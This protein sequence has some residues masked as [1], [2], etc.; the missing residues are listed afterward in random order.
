MV[1]GEVMYRK[2]WCG[3]S[4]GVGGQVVWCWGQG[5]GG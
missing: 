5:G 2:W 1:V 4:G 3:G